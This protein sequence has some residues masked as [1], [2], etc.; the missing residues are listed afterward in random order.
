MNSAPEAPVL[1]N[2]TQL[3]MQ[4]FHSLREPSLE[5]RQHGGQWLVLPDKDQS[6]VWIAPMQPGIYK[7]IAG[8]RGPL[9]TIETWQNLKSMVKGLSNHNQI[10]VLRAWV[11]DQPLYVGSDMASLHSHML[12]AVPAVEQWAKANEGYDVAYTWWNLISMLKELQELGGI[13]HFHFK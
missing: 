1:G 7:A 3:H 11:M 5:E 9:C 8:K 2:L 12:A 10:Q 13:L 4:H 6:R